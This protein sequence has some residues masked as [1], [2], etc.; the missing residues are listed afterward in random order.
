MDL[1]HQI[2]SETTTLLIEPEESF[3]RGIQLRDGT[4]IYT[5]SFGT[6]HLQCFTTAIEHLKYAAERGHARAYFELGIMQLNRQGN[7]TIS[8]D[9]AHNYFSKSCDLG[10]KPALSKRIET[11]KM[12]QS[13]SPVI[14]NL[15]YNGRKNPLRFSKSTLKAR[16][17]TKKGK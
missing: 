13:F 15:I 17:S 2:K 3:Q 4:F 7:K 1:I 12:I 16:S 14:E 5:T 11:F 6:K 10:Y 9:L 8:Y